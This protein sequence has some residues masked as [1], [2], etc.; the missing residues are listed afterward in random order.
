MSRAEKS[1]GAPG[2]SLLRGQQNRS[3]QSESYCEIGRSLQSHPF[4][5]HPCRPFLWLCCICQIEREQMCLPLAPS[6]VAGTC[7]LLSMTNLHSVGHAFKAD[8]GR[9]I[10]PFSP[11]P[12]MLSL[13]LCCTGRTEVWKR[14]FAQLHLLWLIFVLCPATHNRQSVLTKDSNVLCFVLECRTERVQMPV[15]CSGIHDMQAGK[16]Y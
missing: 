11:H 4:P 9:R 1:E 15:P 6:P 2:E 7:P 12:Y 10:S 3:Y 13:C 14:P 8:T 16:V 5:Q